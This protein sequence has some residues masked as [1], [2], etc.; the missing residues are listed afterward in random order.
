MTPAEKNQRRLMR[1]Q[2]C[3]HAAVKIRE[4]LG[5]S[6]GAIEERLEHVRVAAL[7]AV[8]ESWAVF[9]ALKAKKII[10]EAEEQ[11]F[12]DWAY[13]ELVRRVSGG[14]AGKIFEEAGHG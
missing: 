11:E 5:G 8:A 3:F 2:L 10:S 13:E 12:L 6:T 9:H 4:K 14:Q 7:G 1:Q